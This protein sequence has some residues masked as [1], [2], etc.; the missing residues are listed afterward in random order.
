MCTKFVCLIYK[1][2][3]KLSYVYD[4]NFI[5]ENFYSVLKYLYCILR[6]NI[7][8]FLIYY[9]KKYKNNFK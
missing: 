6:I 2:I 7:I 4:R 3:M 5:I 8:L 9:L 1:N